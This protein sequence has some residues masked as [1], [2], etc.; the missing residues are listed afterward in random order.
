MR[1][2]N[3][4]SAGNTLCIGKGFEEVWAYS[5]SVR[6]MLPLLRS[7]T[8]QNKNSGAVMR[9]SRCLFTH[10]LFQAVKQMSE[11]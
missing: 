7:G 4:K 9:P 2:D 11:S 3:E 5:R 1:P 10:R 8:E 6:T